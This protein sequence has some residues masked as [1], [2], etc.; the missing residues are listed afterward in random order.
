MNDETALECWRRVFE[1]EEI[2]IAIQ[3]DPEELDPKALKNLLYKVKPKTLGDTIRLVLPGDL[4][5]IWLVKEATDL[6]SP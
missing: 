4:N 3:F 6:A 5:E 1:D 2:G